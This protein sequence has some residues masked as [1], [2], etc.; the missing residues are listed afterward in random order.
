MINNK[1]SYQ[2]KQF[3]L[4]TFRT[5]A[6]PKA[7]NKLKALPGVVEIRDMVDSLKRIYHTLPQLI[8]GVLFPKSPKELCEK[9][10]I[11]FRPVSIVSELN[12][13][14]AYMQNHWSTLEWFSEKKN[15]FEYHFML[16]DFELCEQ[17]LS[18]IQQRLG[19]SL[20]YYEAKCLLY[21][22]KGL[23]SQK[24]DF[25][26]NVLNECK[27]NM[28]Y[29]PSLIY[30][31]YE[32]T[33]RRLSPYKFD[34]DL[35][36]LYKKN[37]TD[38]HEDFYKYMLFRL[39]FYNQYD[40]VEL[41][42]PIMFESLSSLIDRY[43]IIVSVIK[44]GLAI[45]MEDSALISK[46]YYLFKKTHDKA[47]YP[48][49]ALKGHLLPNDYYNDDFIKMIDC[50]YIGDYSSVLELAANVIKRSPS[51]FDAYVF[52]C[53]AL[54]YQECEYLNLSGIDKQSPTNEICR[55]VY[56]VLSYKEVDDNL[57]SLY[58]IN[59]NLYSFQI[60]ASLDFFV[61]KEWNEPINDN[62]KY[63]YISN[64]DPLCSQMWDNEEDALNYIR[65]YE[66]KQQ[67]SLACH[68]WEKRIRH[69]SVEKMNVTNHIKGPII[70]DYYFHKG[71]YPTAYN[72]CNT[73]YDSANNC[74]PIRQIAV[75]LKIKCLFQQNKTQQAINEYVD[76]YVNDNPSVA[77]VDTETIIKNLQENL[78]EGIRRTVNLVIFVALTCKDTV[79]KSFILLEFCELQKAKVPSELIEKLDVN[80]YGV[81]KLEL[82]F[83]LMNDDET[84]RHYLNIDSFKER[85]AERKKILQF[86][87]SLNTAN[88]ETYQ[89]MLKKVDD[90][91]L[92]YNLSRKI[93]E[94]KI[95]A[96]DEAIIN[97]K[98]ADIDGLFNRYKLLVET[99]I[100]RGRHIFVVDFN[101]SSFFENQ[102]AYE[103]VTNTKTTINSNGLF[104]VFNSLY[105]DIREQFLNSDYGL[106]AYLSTRVRHGELETMLRPEMVHR[107]LILSM[108]NNEY[109]ADMYWTQTYDLRSREQNIV[110]SALIKFSRTFDD[111]VMFLIKEKLQIYNKSQKPNGLFNYEVSEKE[112]ACKAIEI[113]VLLRDG[114]N[115]RVHFCQLMLKWLWEKTEE[116]L[117]QI[118][119]YI[120][121][122]FMN[123]ISKAI[124]TLETTIQEEMPD[125]YAKTELLAQ[126]RSA[127][128]AVTMKIQKVSK[129]FTVSQPKIE[130]V[131]FKA[132]SHQVYNSVRLSHIN[133][134]TDDQLVIKG[135]SFKIKSF[136]VIHYADILR[137]I[138]YN[139]FEHGVDMPDG[140]RHFEL[141]ISILDD[142]VLIDFVNDT[143]GDPEELNAIFA[144]KIK[145]DTSIFGEG[146]SGIAKVNKILKRDL[147]NAS[148]S[149]SMKVE[150][151]K[152]Y[153]TVV[154]KLNGFKAI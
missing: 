16:G 142:D 79:D 108:R 87:I 134:R 34:E 13:A 51:L 145:G 27:N 139:M 7:I 43:L 70:I 80:V 38:L 125:G 56:E 130:D 26:S 52:Y 115:D 109:Q 31:L 128:E 3:Y 57:Y 143:D 153:T 29:I 63:L 90:A 35:N 24:I 22:Y 8:E 101:N 11:F 105:V 54:I 65:T 55:I 81:E 20:W 147:N 1:P 32:R 42:I 40:K 96:N 47:L 110:N 126:I 100:K 25:I 124:S 66:P 2:L 61:K 44:S 133:C 33:S 23:H 150:N 149:I 106:V 84:L 95:Y 12:W 92:V 46:A 60:A 5:S 69:E 89:T 62:L 85:L 91:L 6:M 41:S 114:D 129:W 138:I 83:A 118:R 48:V 68:V 28:N 103:R 9:A 104:E 88:K 64:F 74:I 18:G 45:N 113:G 75:S 140:K 97:Y 116:S 137:N 73:L 154:I 151:G 120:D 17:L 67:K 77:K 82:F 19:T 94:S 136:Y 15:E 86:I 127:R 10:P 72:H 111:A 71:L 37:K 99:L 141:N 148:N 135:T 59:K 112:L 152:C 122:D 131:D 107:N 117:K 58:Q 4:R 78:Y 14:F 49:M 36:A 102:D 21:E 146:G 93:D 119:A 39:N 98:L 53:R 76:Y 121:S 132:V 144:E 30:N 50:Y 123:V